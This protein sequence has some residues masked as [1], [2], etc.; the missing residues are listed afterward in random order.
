MFLYKK[1]I[2]IC[3]SYLTRVAVGDILNLPRFNGNVRNYTD[4]YSMKRKGVSK[5]WVKS[6]RPVAQIPLQRP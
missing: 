5:N 2:Q 3:Q 1:N 4:G 6:L